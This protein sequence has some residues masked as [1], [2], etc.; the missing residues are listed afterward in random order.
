MWNTPPPKLKTV[1]ARLSEKKTFSVARSQGHISKFITIKRAIAV[2]KKDAMW[3]KYV[4]WNWFSLGISDRSCEKK[5][6]NV[7]GRVIDS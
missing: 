5:S 3:G 6:S 2:L 1:E 4:K 7:P